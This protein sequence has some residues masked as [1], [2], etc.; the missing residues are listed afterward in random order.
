[1]HRQLPNLGR[2]SHG[3]G[4]AASWLQPSSSLTAGAGAAR[5]RARA[6]VPAA[7]SCSH[8]ASLTAANLLTCCVCVCVCARER[9]C[10]CPCASVHSLAEKNKMKSWNVEPGRLLFLLN[11]KTSLKPFRTPT[12]LRSVSHPFQ[13]RFPKH[14]VLPLIEMPCQKPLQ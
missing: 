5:V 7:G 9:A 11:F 12:H 6:A 1:M 4:E 10:V 2:F 8:A 14:R 13:P 3:W